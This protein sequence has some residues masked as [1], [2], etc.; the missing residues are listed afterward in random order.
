[1]IVKF[2]KYTDKERILI[3]DDKLPQTSESEKEEGREVKSSSGNGPK[4]S[5]SP[6]FIENLISTFQGVQGK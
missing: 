3:A 4:Q 6:V 5:S 2:T 1:M